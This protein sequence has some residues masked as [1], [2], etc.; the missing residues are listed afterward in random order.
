VKVD[1][2]FYTFPVTAFS[3]EDDFRTALR[4]L[5]TVT[6][7]SFEQRA[8]LERALESRIAIEQAKGILSERL[9]LDLDQAFEV[10]R[11]AARCS[12]RRAHDVALEVVQQKETPPTVLA[13]LHEM[14]RDRP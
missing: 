10:L 5:L 7:S 6:R 2:S 3:A 9:R 8:Q 13:A 1:P 12:R 4:R 14:L 11:R